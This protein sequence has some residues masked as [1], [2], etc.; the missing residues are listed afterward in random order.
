MPEGF[1]S[2]APLNLRSTHNPLSTSIYHCLFIFTGKK[3]VQLQCFDCQYHNTGQLAGDTGGF[4]VGQRE[5]GVYM[6]LSQCVCVCV[7]M[8]QETF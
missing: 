1:Y 8:C 3:E 5:I 4:S 7:C 2:T 6:I